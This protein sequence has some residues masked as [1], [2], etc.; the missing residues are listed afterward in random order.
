MSIIIRMNNRLSIRL[1]SGTVLFIVLMMQSPVVQAVELT[2]RLSLLGMAAHAGQGDAGFNTDNN[3]LMADQQSLR[4]MLDD[5]EEDLEW[6]VHLRAT[7][8]DFIR[9]LPPGF[10]S[11]DLFR[12]RSLSGDWQNDVTPQR[13][14]RS[15]YELDRAVYKHRFDYVTVAIGR[16]PVDWGSGRFWQPL[17]VFGAF[18]PTDLDTDFKPGIDAVVVDW[19]PSAFSSITMAYVPRSDASP[20]SAAS[21]V[22][23]YRSQVGDLSEVALLTGSVLGKSVV[24][25]SYESEF[26]G[27]G[28]RLEALHYKAAK[29]AVFWIV[30]IDYQFEDSTLLAIEWYDN[31]AGANSEAMLPSTLNDPRVTYGL[32]KHM[33]RRVLGMSLSRDITPLLHGSYS[34]LVNGLQD[35]RNRLTVSSLHQMSLTYS[36]SDESDLLISMLVANGKGLG[37]MGTPQS[38]FG[39]IPASATLR[40]RFYF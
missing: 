17:N 35:N 4:L 32:Q 6:S 30:G 39:H 29:N 37:L 5:R 18:S 16:Q 13:T 33:G 21:G 3:L 19:Y 31:S 36:V 14:S 27:I 1:F 15:G 11:S 23:H 25:A 8:Q 28:W 26:K 10:H 24:G 40:Y 38:E 12:Y 34:L 20:A 9:M 2:G 22:I 7:R